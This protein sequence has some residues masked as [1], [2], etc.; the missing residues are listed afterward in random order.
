LL[1]SSGS[2]GS[3]WHSSCKFSSNRPS[4]ALIRTGNS[5]HLPSQGRWNERISS[6][7][8]GS[9]VS[10]AGPATLL[11]I[12]SSSNYVPTMRDTFIAAIH[13]QG[14]C[15]GRCRVCESYL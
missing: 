10:I 1:A 12:S 13:C 15:A 7:S 3:R 14:C 5:C 11:D 6:S 4:C 9:R 8:Q 2:L